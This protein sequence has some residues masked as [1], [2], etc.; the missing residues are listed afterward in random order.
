MTNRLFLISILFLLFHSAIGQSIT[1]VLPKNIDPKSNYLFYLHGRI[2]EDQGVNAISKDYGVY[3]YRKILDT[4]KAAGFKVISEAR[5]RNTDNDVYASK[6]VKLIDSLIKAKVPGENITVVGASKGAGIAI[7]VSSK[8][9]NKKVNFVIMG[10]CGDDMDYSLDE[11]KV[12]GNILSIFEKS[13]PFASSCQ[14]LFLMKSNCLGKSKEVELNLGLG[15]GFLYKPYKE[16][17]VP[18]INWAK[19]NSVSSTRLKAAVQ[20]TEGKTKAVSPIPGADQI[21]KYLP[22]L[23]GKKIGIV[24]NQTSVIGSVPSVDTLLSLGVNIVRIFGPEHGFR[25][26][27]SNGTKVE[28]EIDTK[29]GIKVVSLYGKHH[30]PGKEDL[31]NIDL[32]IYDI[33]DIGAR[34]YTYI[35]TLHYV[36]EACAE[37]NKELMILDRPNPN[38]FYV[39]GPILEDSLHSGIGMHKIPIVHGLT[40]GEF[41]QMLNGEG[42][43]KNKVQCRLTIIKALN[44][45]HDSP[46]RL[47]VMPSPN[48]NTQQAIL[49]YPS[50][51][52]FEG[53]IISQ[54]RGTYY[55]FTVLGAPALNGKYKFSFSPQSIKGMSETPLHQGL[56]CYGL[57]LRKINTDSLRKIKQINLSWLIE[58]YKIYPDKEKFFDFKQSKQMGNFDLLAGTKKLKRQIISGTTEEEIRKSWEPGLSEFKL[59]RKE[60]LLYP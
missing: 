1:T 41:A 6:V 25:G 53:T 37:N 47:P 7:H 54:G 12:C 2:I 3:E 39:D 56:N 13:D 24:V 4:L 20:S 45:T 18:A 32:M 58:L 57:D 35:N 51:C 9:K 29:T 11:F 8:L 43:L 16:W 50:L 36:M 38:G 17:V 5:P 48:I 59:M 55:P 14:K 40:I 21:S 19:E 34:F 28:D 49:L 26:N 52:L 46:Y 30:K 10:V 60:Y 33:Q 22:Y 27:A 15:H 44:Y 42:W 31:E 23:K